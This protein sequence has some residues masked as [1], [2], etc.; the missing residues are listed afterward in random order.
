[1]TDL[2]S[3]DVLRKGRF[4]ALAVWW[5][6]LASF[7]LG[8]TWIAALIIAHVKQSTFRGTL[9]QGHMTYAIRTFWLAVAWLLIGLA[10]FFTAFFARTPLIVSVFGEA[11]VGLVP[12]WFTARCVL[13]LV[14][15]LDDDPVAR[16]TALL[17]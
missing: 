10:M 9:W 15:A 17:F 7:V 6:Y 1:M 5:L 13:G 12:L 8:I 3:N 14:K 16:P 2:A 11:I 4:W